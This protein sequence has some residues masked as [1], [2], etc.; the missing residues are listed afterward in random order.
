M[1]LDIDTNSYS[2]IRLQD[3]GSHDIIRYKTSFNVENLFINSPD[4]LGELLV[5][6]AY[7]FEKPQYIRDILGEAVGHGLILAEGEQHK[8]QRRDL[9]PAFAFRHI[10]NLYPVFWKKARES[11][12][13][14]EN[15]ITNSGNPEININ[16]W[17]SSTSLDII[18]VAGMGRDFG[19]I[20]DPDNELVQS[21]M[22]LSRPSAGDRFLILLCDWIGN[23]LPGSLLWQI[24]LPRLLEIK[25]CRRV[26]RS[27]C[28]DLIRSKREKLE[29][30]KLEDV[31]ILSTALRSRLFTEEGVLHQV[32]NLLSAGHDTVASTL[33]WAIYLLSVY[34]E[35]Q[36]RLRDEIRQNLPSLDDDTPI[37][38]TDIDRL[39]YLKAVVLETARLYSPLP[40]TLRVAIRD[41][42]LGGLAIPKHTRIVISPWGTHADPKLWGE[43][44]VKFRPERWLT[45]ENGGFAKT[46]SEA[47]MG[48]AES[49]YAYLAFLHG[50]RS[51]IG[52]NFAKAEM[53]CVLANWV[54][55]FEFELKDKTLMDPEKVFVEQL[56]TARAVEDLIVLTKVV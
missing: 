18:G 16:K 3:I 37:S 35:I 20:Q 22:G 52:Q 43:D 2:S 29:Q 17:A 53:A 9:L 49:N 1:T 15:T 6:K 42:S 30:D 28:R 4:L 47:S 32:M 8:V 23:V 55:R 48:G 50:P 27:V 51:C 33:G 25:R 38:S 19:A 40:N 14:I 7:D 36:K 21:Y 24:P 45:V 46:A 10:K 34:P 44:P 26:I 39:P 5:T 56:I 12:R 11:T 54:G 31:D 13:A 41:T